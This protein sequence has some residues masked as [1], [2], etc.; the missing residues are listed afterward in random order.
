M[1]RTHTCGELTKGN[2]G[3]AVQLAGWVNS[4]RD[5]GGLIFI[6][7]RD[8]YGITQCTFDPKISKEAWA[9]AEKVRTEY[10]VQAEGEVRERPNEMI[11]PNLETGEIEIAVKKMTVLTKS[12][13]PPFEI[14]W[15]PELSEKDSA[16]DEKRIISEDVR[17][18]YRYLDLRR[19]KMLKNIELRHHLITYTREYLNQENFLEIET[20]I[21]TKSTPEGARDYI[22]PS[23][24]HPGKF[25]ALPQS[26]QQ[27][28]QLLMMA[29]I[30]RYYQ[31]ARCF[32]DEDQRGD[33]QPEFTQLDLEM[34]FVERDDVINCTENLFKIVFKR[35]IDDKL[36]NKK[37]V[38]VL[39]QL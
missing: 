31:I 12:K 29:G 20:P 23:R 9:I 5:H 39:C 26:P 18:K 35:L 7:L 17:L 4:R 25:Y 21:L 22:V 2:I 6:D 32:R 27:Y 28:K 16:S 33:R 10:V 8:R 19:K 36:V 15:R 13:T 24:L 1:Y 37:I 34:S 38:L 3:K 11:N 30:D 14:E